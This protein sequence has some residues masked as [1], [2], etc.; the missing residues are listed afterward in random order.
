[1]QLQGPLFAV[2]TP[3]GAD[4]AV[5]VG[6]LR[7]V[8]GFLTDRGVRTIIAN[9]TTGEFP[10]LS[11]RER[12]TVL[13]ICRAHFAGQ[14]VANVSACAVGQ[15]REHASAAADLSDAFLLLPPFYYA[16]SPAE[17]LVRFF[18]A[19]LV[20]ARRPALLYNFPRH[21]QNPISAATYARVASAC[22]AVLGIKE[23][24]G[25]LETGREK[26]EAVTRG[27]VF[28][29]GDGLA[30]RALEAGLDGSA[31]GAGNPIPEVLVQIEA[32][33]RQG[34]AARA[35]RIQAEGNWW[36]EFRKTLDAGDIV[37]AKAALRHRLP[38]FPVAVRPP[39]IAADE[40]MGE[41]IARAFEEWRARS[42]DIEWKA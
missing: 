20:D 26:K 36:V 9:G 15:V 42:R 13:R 8:L 19:C 30:L 6:A 10:S 3:F 5:D 33:F 7:E 2:V 34:E 29:G 37:V 1:M 35:G 32:A 39:L 28:L 24:T 14:I 4:G 40:A 21:T 22:G 27:Q 38:G 11:A 23:T 17:G 41:R 12:E 16:A 18:E 31:T 25:D